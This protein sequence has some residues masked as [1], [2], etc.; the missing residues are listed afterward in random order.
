MKAEQRKSK[1]DNVIEKGNDDV[2]DHP[3]RR[4]SIPTYLMQTQNS[5]MTTMIPQQQTSGYD[6]NRIPLSIFC[7]KPQEW[8]V[9]SNDLFS[10]QMGDG[11]FSH[12]VDFLLL[13]KSGESREVTGKGVSPGGS[14]LDL[15]SG[16]ISGVE[17]EE[18]LPHSP[19]AVSEAKKSVS[20]AMGPSSP[21]YSDGSENSF[22]SFAFPL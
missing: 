14:D 4:D 19:A 18:E 16:K 20:P 15:D 5:M 21:H 7:N 6:P 12:D 2:H 10:I 17:V 11:S 22:S 13:G 9:Q 8:S 1:E 3:P